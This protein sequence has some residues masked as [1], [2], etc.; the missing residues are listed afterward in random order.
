MN[1]QCFCGC[2]EFHIQ[3]KTYKYSLICARCK[4]ERQIIS[5]GVR[6]QEYDVDILFHQSNKIIDQTDKGR[7]R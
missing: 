6:V 4:C 1:E 7:K 5:P 3:K 2:D